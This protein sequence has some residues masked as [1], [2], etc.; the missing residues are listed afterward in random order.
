LDWAKFG[1]GALVIAILF[2]SGVGKTRAQGYFA[3][4]EGRPALVLE[5]FEGPDATVS[6]VQYGGGG[7]RII[8]N[9]SS[10]SG[11]S[12]YADKLGEH[13]MVW[14]G[15]L[16]MLLHP[17]PQHALVI[18]FGTGQ[19]ANAVR[20]ENPTSLDIVDIN[21]NIFK[22]AHHFSSNED[23]LN[24]PKVKAIVMDGRAYLRRST[25]TY[26]VITLEPMPPNDAGVNALYSKEFYELARNRLS[27]KG[28]IAQWLPFHCVAPLYS[29]SV[30]KTFVDVF[31]NAV[32][33][34]DPETKRDG[35]LLATKDDAVDLATTWPGFSRTV[36]ERDLD[37]A[38]VRQSVFLNPKQLRQYAAYG[39]VVSDDNQL[40]NYGNALFC[41]IGLVNEN[42][43]L[44]RRVNP[45]IVPPE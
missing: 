41:N 16:P 21:P 32:L 1:G 24:D 25:K 2:E 11:Q 27:P 13:Y 4:M 37:E 6:V 19:T 35:I 42:F 34:V 18:C 15:R 5:A 43:D 26:D 14:M 23:V 44:L 28:V 40:L 17:D 29:A 22:L 39:R 36:M 9:A 33:W 3:N 31:P 7:R 8:I 38:G 10:A 12:G 45:K 20:K 30:A